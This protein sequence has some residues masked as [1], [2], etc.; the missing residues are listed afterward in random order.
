MSLTR[1]CV[2]LLAGLMLV[3]APA[4]SKGKKDK[5][6]SEKQPKAVKGAG[7]T[8]EGLQAIY[9]KNADCKM[10]DPCCAASTKD[11]VKSFCKPKGRTFRDRAPGET[12]EAKYVP[13]WC[14]NQLELLRQTRSTNNEPPAA[15][16]GDKAG[17]AKTGD[18]KGG[19]DK[20][21]DKAGGDKA[22]AV[23]VGKLPDNAPKTCKKL[24]SCCT[25]L[26]KSK[27]AMAGGC[28]STMAAVDG[29][30]MA[31][32]AADAEKQCKTTLGGFSK[33]PGAPAACK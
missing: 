1:I 9:D 3:T 12:V 30:M 27:P 8:S 7:I 2:G 29:M 17:G 11:M 5:G 21:G 26:A 19:D 16:C 20:A 6:E 28:K 33:M 13:G 23:D 24:L 4:C 10:L 25:A 31:K 22:A 32:K 14:K 18:D 15:A